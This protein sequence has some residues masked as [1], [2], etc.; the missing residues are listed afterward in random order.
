MRMEH[1]LRSAPRGPTHRLR[2]APPLVADR[3][4]ERERTHLEALTLGTGRVEIPLRWVEL[5]LVLETGDRSV[6][7]DDERREPRH[8]V[9]Q[10]LGAE[11]HRDADGGRGVGERGPRTFEEAS[12]ERWHRPVHRTISRHVAFRKADDER[13]LNRRL[14][15]SRFG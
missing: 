7:I 3:Y 1:H 6:S 12:I 4:A 11:H 9:D 14:R 13:P 5:H 15:D 8:V 10:S 2:I